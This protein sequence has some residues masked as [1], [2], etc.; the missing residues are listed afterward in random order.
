M[1]KHKYKIGLLSY[2]RRNDMRY[3]D[4]WTFDRLNERHADNSNAEI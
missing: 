2:K 4:P 1:K 3:Y